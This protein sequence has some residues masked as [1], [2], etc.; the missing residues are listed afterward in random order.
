MEFTFA[1]GFEFL[2]L[3]RVWTHVD[4]LASESNHCQEHEGQTQ[5][6]ST[7][8]PGVLVVVVLVAGAPATMPAE[9]MWKLSGTCVS[10]MQAKTEAS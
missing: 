8:W 6:N 1:P 9:M 10:A 7:A 5:L 2:I 4:S 3:L